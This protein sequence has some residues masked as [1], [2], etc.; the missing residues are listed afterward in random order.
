MAKW[1]IARGV[2]PIA[3]LSIAAVTAAACNT[4]QAP[5]VARVGVNPNPSGY[6]CYFADDGTAD[7]VIGTQT[8]HWCGPVP[9][10]VQ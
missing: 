8:F 4:A 6:S 5:S 7:R 2:F 9:R 10:A 1:T 3:A